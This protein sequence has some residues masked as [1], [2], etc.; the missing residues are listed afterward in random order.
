MKTDTLVRNEGMEILA[1][2]LSLVDAERFIMLILNSTHG[3]VYS[4]RTGKTPEKTLVESP[5][6]SLIRR[7]TDT[8]TGNSKGFSGL[9]PG[10]AAYVGVGQV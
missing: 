8:T 10:P 4:S 7:I 2:N 9:F 5:S 3:T 6:L 1:Q